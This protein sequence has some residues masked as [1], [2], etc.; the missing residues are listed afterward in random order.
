MAKNI[1]AIAEKLGAK[2]VAEI[3]DV[4]GGA[5]GAARLAGIVATLQSRMQ[6]GQGKRPGRP[7]VVDWVTTPKVPMS[8]ATEAKL[9]R[10]AIRAS[11]DGRRVSPM[12]LAAQLLEEAVAALPET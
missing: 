12:Q 3:P 6:P 7:S 5:F 4:G 11:A 2:V 1:A 8:E 10:L 9:S